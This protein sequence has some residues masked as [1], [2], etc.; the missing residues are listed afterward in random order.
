MY[1]LNYCI[2][3]VEVGHFL[4]SAVEYV[5]ASQHITPS[6]GIVPLQIIPSE[7]GGKHMIAVG[8]NW[9]DNEKTVDGK[10]THALNSILI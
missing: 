5:C 6:D 7:K 8:D 4:T 10:T 1:S 9:D 2:S 3:Y